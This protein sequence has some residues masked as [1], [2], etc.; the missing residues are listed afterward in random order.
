M[1]SKCAILRVIFEWT[2]RDPSTA[3]RAGACI[4][5]RFSSC[6]LMLLL[7]AV[8]SCPGMPQKTQ[9]HR[10][11]SA[12]TDS[13]SIDSCPIVPGVE[14]QPCPSM[15]G[16]F[17]GCPGTKGLRIEIDCG[18]QS[19]RPEGTITWHNKT[20]RECQSTREERQSTLKRGLSEVLVFEIAMLILC[21]VAS[22]Y[23]VKKRYQRHAEVYSYSRV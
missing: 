10:L 15:E 2:H 5:V 22:G 18:G 11:S 3:P 8:H 16:R 4:M 17:V 21:C 12:S 14:C 19:L 13:E 23:I 20:W 7:S 1:A 9:P 6:W